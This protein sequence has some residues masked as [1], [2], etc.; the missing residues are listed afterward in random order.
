VNTE[1]C[2]VVLAAGE[3]RRL[4]PLT[5]HLPKALCP[6]GNVALLDRALE[7]VEALKLPVAVNACYLGS[8]VAEHVGERAH[9]SVE[10]DAPLGTAGGLGRLREW[11]GGRGVLVGN[12]DAYLSSALAPGADIAALLEG[13]DGAGVR[14]LGVPGPPFE[15]G[16]FRFAGFSLL[17]WDV[18]ARLEPEPS[19]LVR[20]AWRPAER[21]GRLSVVEYPGTYLDTGT[22]AD[23]LAANLLAGTVIAEDA[24]VTGTVESGVVGSGAVVAGRVTRGVVWPGGVVAAGET[25]TDAIRVGRELTVAAH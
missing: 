4:R 22:P 12:A 2:A 8:M 3:G 16:A 19:D 10:P 25:L 23:Y 24:V 17:P 13:W 1:L 15:F 6:V 5:E 20:V 18:V 14:L 11:I 9:V 21:A 7:R